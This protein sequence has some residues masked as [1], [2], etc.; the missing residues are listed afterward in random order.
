MDGSKYQIGNIFGDTAPESKPEV[1]V[2]ES[3]GPGV[4]KSLVPN[5]ALVTLMVVI[6]QKVSSYGL[7]FFLFF[8][9]FLNFYFMR[10]K[11]FFPPLFY[12]T[13]SDRSTPVSSAP[14]QE[15]N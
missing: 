4:R 6:K 10:C 5:I 8:S 9:S 7:I 13:E 15:S 1:Y 14:F 12:L 11:L 2:T 3:K